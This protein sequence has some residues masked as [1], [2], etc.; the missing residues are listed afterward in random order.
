MALIKRK[1]HEILAYCPSLAM[2]YAT[3]Y[4]VYK[5]TSV[6]KALGS[7]VQTLCYIMFTLLT[8]KLTTARL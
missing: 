7:K 8:I 5:L 4:H 2:C 1:I 3:L 6:V